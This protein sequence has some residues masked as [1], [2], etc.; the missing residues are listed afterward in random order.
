M[1]RAYKDYNKT[2]GEG[3]S[4]THGKQ[5]AVIKSKNHYWKQTN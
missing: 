5:V 2:G 3:G 1:Y 4:S